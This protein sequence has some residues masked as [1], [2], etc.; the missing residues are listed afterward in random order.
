MKTK[1]IIAAAAMAGA[2]LVK[3][4]MSKRKIVKYIAE[5]VPLKKSHH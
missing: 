1:I 2:L 5:A 4:I 3:Y